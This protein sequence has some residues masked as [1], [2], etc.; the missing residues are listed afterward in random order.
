MLRTRI[1]IAAG[2]LGIIAACNTP[3]VPIPPPDLQ[4]LSFQNSGAAPAG[5]VVLQGMPSQRHANAEFFALNR[6]RG[7]GV[8]ATAGAD[9][10]FT[11]SPFAAN[12]GDTMQLYYNTSSG[13][14]SEEVCVQ[15]VINL[16]LISSACP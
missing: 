16:P 8:I 2:A 1:L 12:D 9:G 7:D 15:L 13:E 10:S 14:H 5:M 6:S 4:A 11:T 3:S